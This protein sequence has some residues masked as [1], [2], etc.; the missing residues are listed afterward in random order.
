MDLALRALETRPDL[1]DKYQSDAD[2]FLFKANDFV[3]PSE[4]SVFGDLSRIPSLAVDARN[5]ATISLGGFDQ[6]PTLVDFL[7]QRN[8]PQPVLVPIRPAAPAT[9]LSAFPVLDA[10]DYG[11]CL[12]HVG[13]R[14]ELVGAVVSVHKSTTRGGKPYVFI[15]FG[16][17]RGQNVKVS[18]WSE[19]LATLSQQPDSSWQGRWVSVV[20]LLEPPFRSA[21]FGYS[22]LAVSIAEASQM[23]V[24]TQSDA[25]FRLL[26]A[27]TRSAGT[28][29]R[30]DNAEVLAAIRRG[31][32]GRPQ[33]SG[34][35]PAT[36]GQAPAAPGRAPA[37]RNQDILLAMKAGQ[38]QLPQRQVQAGS[39]TPVLPQPKPPARSG[40][41]TT[42]LGAVVFLAL[43]MAMVP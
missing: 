35:K 5:F 28:A 24:I 32:G 29:E 27:N 16:D 25:K 17:W 6:I 12:G 43:V 38:P 34:Q 23:H 11:R 31:G 33:A 20:G 10:A 18:I 1:W 7:A 13:D 30:G 21:S 2:S 4:S 40:C 42:V 41:L 37:T 14:I 22:H 15:N 3:R 36:S 19:G 26:G 39:R 8:L 9:Y